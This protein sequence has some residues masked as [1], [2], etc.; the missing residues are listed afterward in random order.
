MA[1]LDASLLAAPTLA[2]LVILTYMLVLPLV[3][4]AGMLMVAGSR[5]IATALPHILPPSRRL[6]P[7]AR[8][9]IVLFVANA[10]VIVIIQ[11][12][13]IF[14][15]GALVQIGWIL[16][17]SR[18]RKLLRFPRRT[19]KQPSIAVPPATLPGSALEPRPSRKSD[20]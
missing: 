4:P 19:W 13:P 9:L 17:T 7:V 3:V 11:D 20:R 10:I 12:I 1:P 16:A 14:S 6:H 5:H 2:N 15:L 8:F 18:P